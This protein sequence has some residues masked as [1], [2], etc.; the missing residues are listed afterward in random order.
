MSYAITKG[1]KSFGPK[2]LL[3]YKDSKELINHQINNLDDPDIDISVVVGFC[4]D[5]VRKKINNISRVNIIENTKYSSYNEAYALELILQNYNSEKY[6]GCL[7]INDGIIFGNSI[8]KI[9][10]NPQEK[11]ISK[12]FYINEEKRKGSI[13]KIGLTIAENKFVQH[14]FYDLTDSLWAEL[15]YINNE[16]IKNI[17]KIYHASMRNMFFFEIVNN[18]IDK[19]L[20]YNPVQVK[21]NSIIKIMNSKNSPMAKKGIK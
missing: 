18:S 15:I 10:T 20:K 21:K 14:M 3:K 5:K 19:G 11:D 16:D 8:K 17:K 12:I 6:S 2:A 4:S 9:V 1:M 7:I 13:F